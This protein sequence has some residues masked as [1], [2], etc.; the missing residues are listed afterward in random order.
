MPEI[1]KDG[2]VDRWVVF[3]PERLRR[4]LQYNLHPLDDADGQPDPFVE[5]RESYTPP[6]VLAI[7]NPGS[8][9][10]GPGWKVRVVPNLFPALRVEGELHKEAVGLYDKMSGVGA[11]EVVIETP[12]AEVE[13]EQQPLENIVNVL[14]A[15]R[16]RLADLTRDTRFHYLFA[17]KNVGA[18]AGASMRHAHSQ[19]IALPVIPPNLREKLNAA[20]KYYAQ[21]DRNLFED[22]LKA[23][24][25]SGE[26]LV[27]Q[28]AGYGA[29]CPFASRF[30]FEVAIMPRQQRASFTACTDH[31]L[32]LLADILQKVLMA[33]RTGLERPSYNLILHTAP[34]RWRSIEEW[35][36]VEH[37]FRWHI[38]IFPRLSGVAGF[39]FG[40]G[41]YINAMFPEDAA[42]FL[43]EV[44]TDA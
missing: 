41:F 30:M 19:I 10:N 11:H 40:T 15:Y 5:G 29:F 32:V 6:E 33:Y 4:P 16:A 43:R 25:K 28:N 20:K 24:L 37:D 12:L 7:R 13:L 27:F 44:K 36:T 17:F 34:V 23:E 38:E 31:E 39:E 26:R 8:A 42:K 21:K 14:K 9:P 2:V 35:D 18:L 1:R 3:S 22:I